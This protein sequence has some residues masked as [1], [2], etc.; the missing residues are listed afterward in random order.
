MNTGMVANGKYAIVSH[1]DENLEGNEMG[2]LAAFDATGKGK[3]PMDSIKW[4]VK[5][6]MGG[7]SSPASRGVPVNPMYVAFGNASRMYL[8]NPYAIR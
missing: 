7:F 4:M 1:G 5:G 2:L 3:L 8:A 6:F